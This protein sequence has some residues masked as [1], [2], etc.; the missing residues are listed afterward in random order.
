MTLLLHTLYLF[1]IAWFSLSFGLMVGCIIGQLVR[2]KE[3]ANLLKFN[4]FFW[5]YV[6]IWAKLFPFMPILYPWAC[7]RKF[8]GTL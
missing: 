6:W 7:Y 8:K 2:D 1:A 4:E 5:T 3:L